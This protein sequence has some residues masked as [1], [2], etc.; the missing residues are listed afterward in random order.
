MLLS[1]SDDVESFFSEREDYDE[2]TAFVFAK[3]EDHSGPENVS[4]IQT[5][6]QIQK[7]QPVIHVPSIKIHILL[8]KFD[9]PVPIIR[10]IDTG[11][12]KSMLNLSI[13]LSHFWEKHTK[14]FKAVDGELFYTNLIAK[15]PIGIQFFPRCV[16][17][18]NLVGSNLPDKDLLIFT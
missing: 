2:K 9:K 7:V 1:E 6:Q 16:L 8:E 14:Y 17:W 13:L 18:V 4:V 11:A 15:K 5:V 3:T 12:Q 10:F